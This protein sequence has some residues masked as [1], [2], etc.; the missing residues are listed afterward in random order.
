LFGRR[1]D[2]TWDWPIEVPAVPDLDLSRM[3]LGSLR[4]GDAV[5]AARGLGRPDR[6]RW[7]DGG[8]CELL[9]ARAGFQLDFEDGRLCYMAFFIGADADGPSHP[10][11]SPSEPRIRGESPLTAETG[12]DDL[13]R[14]FGPPGSEDSDDDETVLYYR[15]D[16][17]TME[18]ELD[19]MGHLKRWN[20]YP[21]DA[22][23]GVEPGGMT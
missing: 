8:Y 14:R 18:F 12:K 3:A 1:P 15:R 13:Q 22:R 17:V 23:G 9:Y 11:L 6:F 4:F 5:E 19:G 16:R 7:K 21:S 20:L 2:P 10:A